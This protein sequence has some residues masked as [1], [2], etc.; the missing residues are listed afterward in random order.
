MM[1]QLTRRGVSAP[2][3]APLARRRRLFHCGNSLIGFLVGRCHWPSKR[4]K[5]GGAA[6]E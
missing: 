5:L 6:H 2:P 1:N 4:R 3:G